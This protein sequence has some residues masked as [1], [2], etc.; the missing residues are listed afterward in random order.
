V[1]VVFLRNWRSLENN[2]VCG[3][4][5]HGLIEDEDGMNFLV[6]TDAAHESRPAP[7]GALMIRA[8]D[9]ETQER[10]LRE[11]FAGWS[12]CHGS[13]EPWIHYARVAG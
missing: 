8:G 5:V 13:A 4:R 11:G 3:L 10:A 12:L 2:L 7:D 1:G 9:L 6:Y